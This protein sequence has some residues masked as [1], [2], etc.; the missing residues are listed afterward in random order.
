[1]PSLCTTNAH[2]LATKNHAKR[3]VAQFLGRN[4]QRILIFVRCTKNT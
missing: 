1:M 2:F 4:N 3:F